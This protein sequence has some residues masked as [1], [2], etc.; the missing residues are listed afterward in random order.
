[1]KI[2]TPLCA[3]FISNNSFRARVAHGPIRDKGGAFTGALL[4]AVAKKIL[5]LKY[6]FFVQDGVLGDRLCYF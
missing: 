4:L 5:Y 2:S 1:M 6:N 3:P